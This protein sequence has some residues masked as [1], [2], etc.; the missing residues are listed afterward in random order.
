MRPTGSSMSCHEDQQELH[1]TRLKLRKA[2]WFSLY[3]GGVVPRELIEGLSNIRDVDT[4]GLL[5]NSTCEQHC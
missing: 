3:Q 2:L 1:G 4:E 5:W